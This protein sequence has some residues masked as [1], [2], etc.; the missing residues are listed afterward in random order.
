[1]GFP[2]THLP[3][4]LPALS[5]FTHQR[6]EYSPD[7]YSQSRESASLACGHGFALSRNDARPNSL[8]SESGFICLRL[9]PALLACVLLQPLIAV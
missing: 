6:H 4:A 2:W 1:M 8:R 5:L 9:A 7:P 3:G